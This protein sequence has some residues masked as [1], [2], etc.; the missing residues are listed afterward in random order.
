ML[1]S[2]GNYTL[3]FAIGGSGSGHAFLT[4]SSAMNNGREGDGCTIQ[5]T[6]G[7]Q[8]TA[9]YTQITVT[10]TSP[11]DATPP[12]GAV[13]V[14]NL[15]G[16]PLGTKVEIGGVVQRLVD[17]PRLGE[18]CAWVLLSATSATLVIKIYNDVN[19][20]ATIAAGTVFAIGE[21]SVGRLCALPSLVNQDAPSRRPVD[22]T[23]ESSTDGGQRWR[24]MRK[25]IWVIQ[26]RLGRFSRAD[27]QG[28]L[29]SSI[30]SGGNPA[31]KIDIKTLQM[32]LATSQF[33]AVCDMPSVTPRGG[34][35]Y[36][37][38]W[39]D[40]TDM[41]SN[42]LLCRPSDLDRLAMDQS[43]LYSW[44]PTWTEAY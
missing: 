26:Q 16:L 17:G 44:N 21:I 30:V 15:Q 5:F 33:C 6:G 12:Q 22:P 9:S 14:I 1:L 36:N 10:I 24:V 3:A 42:W 25:P 31:A 40:Q 37:G 13:G 39:W 32:I 18:L 19:G 20:V 35:N 38:V 29:K 34:T 43:P 2:Y 27:V 41:Q 23:A 11:Y 4:P 8:T 28:K 7:A